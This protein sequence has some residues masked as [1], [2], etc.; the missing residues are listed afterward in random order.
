MDYIHSDLWGPSQVS[1]HGGARYFMTLI[2]DFTRK[3]WVYILK[4]KSEALLKFKEWMTL[5]ENQTERK[6][7]RLRTDNGLEY[8]SKEFDSFCKEKG[9]VRHKTVRHT[10]QQNGLAERMNMTLVEKVR[11]MLFS[12]NLSKHLWADAVTTAAYLINRSPST[13]LNFKTPQ[14]A[15]SGKTPDL[16]NLRIFGSPA[17][18]HIKQ[19]KL[20]PRAIKGIFIGYP[21]GVKGYR[22]WCCDGKPSRVIVSRDIIFDDDIMLHQKVETELIAPEQNVS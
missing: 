10:P 7:K 11:C 1:S 18:A 6:V 2:D 17:Y 15:W 22:I 20:E 5:I 14:E 3:V 16:S 13:A 21:E 8:R 19:G 4:H 9:I 12:A